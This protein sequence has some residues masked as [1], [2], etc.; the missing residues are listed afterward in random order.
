MNAPG[1]STIE[2]TVV[3]PTFNE[4][5]NVALLVERLD[6]ALGGIAWEVVFVDDDSPDET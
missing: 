4:R 5:D 3:V 1:I 2:L 6:A